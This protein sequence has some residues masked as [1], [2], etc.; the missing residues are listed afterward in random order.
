M[1]VVLMEI[2][3]MFYCLVG[4]VEPYNVMG[5]SYFKCAS[6]EEFMVAEL[7]NSFILQESFYY[8]INILAT[9]FSYEPAADAPLP[10]DC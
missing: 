7:S 5:D 2:V 1:S 9:Q 3:W 8:Q 10:T 4:Q 6:F